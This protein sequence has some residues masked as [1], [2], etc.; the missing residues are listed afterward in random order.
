MYQRFA[1]T[2]EHA[3]YTTDPPTPQ[4]HFLTTLTI[5]ECADLIKQSCFIKV[6]SVRALDL[7]AFEL[8][9]RTHANTYKAPAR[10]FTPNTFKVSFH[11]TIIYINFLTVN[12]KLQ[13]RPET[14]QVGP[15]LHL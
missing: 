7:R 13:A 6:G 12:E 15:K 1:R 2:L 8:S 9:G 11:D 14:R 4:G 10:T 5:F 3:D